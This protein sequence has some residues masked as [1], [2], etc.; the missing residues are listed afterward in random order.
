MAGLELG[1]ERTESW[2]GC[3]SLEAA[4]FVMPGTAQYRASY[5][6]ALGQTPGLS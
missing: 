6:S 2:Q 3:F 1:A 4:W 5:G